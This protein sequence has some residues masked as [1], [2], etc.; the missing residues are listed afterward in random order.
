MRTA[1][2]KNSSVLH[3]A[4]SCSAAN[5]LARYA[6]SSAA[7]MRSRCSNSLS[8]SAVNR[9]GGRGWR[10]REAPL[11]RSCLRVVDEPPL[12]EGLRLAHAV[13]FLPVYAI[14]EVGVE[15]ERD[16]PAAVR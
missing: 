9:T 2:M 8:G 3:S 10:M 16:V 11:R 5:P 15:D 12:A 6:R 13:D 7:T 4:I 14:A 1:P